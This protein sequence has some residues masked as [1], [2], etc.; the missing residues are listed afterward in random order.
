M[1]KSKANWVRIRLSSVVL[2]ASLICALIIVSPAQAA[3]TCASQGNFYDGFLSP[4]SSSWT[5]EGVSSY[6][7]V[8]D[9][10]TCTGP[11]SAGPGNFI[12]T[13]VLVAGQRR[14]DYAQVG[15]DRQ[16]NTSLRWFSEYSRNGNRTVRFGGFNI[17]SERGV[18]H[19]FRVLWTAACGGCMRMYIDTT[20]WDSSTFNPFDAVADGGWDTGT[21]PI[22]RPQFLSEAASRESDVPG[23][24]TD[25][26]LYTG[27][28][29]QRI[30][31][32]QIQSVPCGLSG[33]NDNTARWARSA[34]GCQSFSL[35]TSVR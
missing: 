34:N 24:S 1:S 18:R 15:F 23:N 28:G 20:L 35:W 8:Q 14:G 17:L 9:G 3:R 25:A 27:M 11:N 21:S 5:Y 16:Q 4:N 19:T 10:L 31:D 2:L 13:W 26:T 7:Y 32:D 22:M 30:S 33:V 29:V 6:I 12:S